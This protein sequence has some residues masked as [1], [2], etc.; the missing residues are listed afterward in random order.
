MP[1][2][3]RPNDVTLPGNYLLGRCGSDNFIR[4]VVH[5]DDNDNFYIQRSWTK[6]Y[7]AEWDSDLRFLGPIPSLLQSS[8]CP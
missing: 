6:D 1:T 8:N 5:V 4:T 7:Q 2:W 3:L